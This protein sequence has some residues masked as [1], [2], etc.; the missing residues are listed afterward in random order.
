MTKDQFLQVILHLRVW[1]K[2]DEVA[3]HKPL[4]V[5]WALARFLR[6]EPRLTEYSEIVCPE[7]KGLLEKFA[8]Q[9][10][11]GLR[12]EEPFSRLPKDGKDAI[13]ELFDPSV[14]AIS[15]SELPSHANLRERKIQGGF[16]KPIFDLLSRDRDFVAEC[17][18]T[19][20]VKHFP[21]TLHDAILTA[22]GLPESNYNKVLVKLIE[23]SHPR[24]PKFR[25]EVL[26]VWQH[27][28]A[29]CEMGIEYS[30]IYPALD[31]AHIRWHC[32]EG[33]D[34]INNGLA[35]CSV[36]HRLFDFGA[37]TIKFD[38]FEVVSDDQVTGIGNDR[39]LA[40]YD[41]KRLDC[42]RFSH[43]DRPAGEFLTWHSQNIFRGQSISTLRK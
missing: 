30:G 17:I 23:N 16:T 15:R 1:R 43:E 29:V 11:S 20:L 28:C 34:T 38:G 31:A 40:K 8:P 2:G 21:S 41:G 12:P 22:I 4:L 5:L 19:L 42:H 39:W 3:P 6:G 13:W 25:R 18:G 35:L 33:P 27:R 26:K 32:R 24:D 37:F 14:G 36:H 7:L 10:P 9:R